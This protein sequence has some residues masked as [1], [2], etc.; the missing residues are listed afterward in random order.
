MATAK[1]RR[2]CC[3]GDRAESPPTPAPA[4]RHAPR[5]IGRRPSS[6]APRREEPSRREPAVRREPA[7]RRERP[8]E[9]EAAPE[10][11]GRELVRRYGRDPRRPDW[12]DTERGLAAPIAT[13]GDSGASSGRARVV[14]TSRCAPPAARP[15][16]RRSAPIH[17][18]RSIAI[19]AIA[20]CEKP[21][22]RRSRRRCRK[23]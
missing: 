17:R 22:A 20:T 14:G 5:A 13:R 3:G 4:A 11:D 12:V 9:H 10:L 8:V 1:P 21:V 19:R 16:R 15:R 6:T 23:L 18:G 7:A 2:G